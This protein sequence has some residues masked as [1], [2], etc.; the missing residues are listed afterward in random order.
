MSGVETHTPGNC[1]DV[2]ALVVVH[3][4]GCVRRSSGET[5]MLP[6]CA[7]EN[8]LSVGCVVTT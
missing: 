1:E 4:C 5:L 3:G 7:N 2:R 8:W 6:V